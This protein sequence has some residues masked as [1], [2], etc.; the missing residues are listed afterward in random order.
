MPKQIWTA[1]EELLNKMNPKF[2]LYFFAERI[3]WMRILSNIEIMRELF[4]VQYYDIQDT[5]IPVFL[6]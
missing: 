6:I 4:P 1:P 2:W 3:E 5:D